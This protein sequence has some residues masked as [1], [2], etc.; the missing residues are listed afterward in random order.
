[1]D[2][3]NHARRLSTLAQM[4]CSSCQSCKPR[5]RGASLRFPLGQRRFCLF[6]TRTGTLR[7]RWLRLPCCCWSMRNGSPCYIKMFTSSN[8]WEAS[9]KRCLAV[10]HV[11]HYRDGQQ[12][13]KR[14]SVYN[15]STVTRH[16][17]RSRLLRT[18]SSVVSE[19]KQSTSKNESRWYKKVRL[20]CFPRI[21]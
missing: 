6:W 21:Q 1:M 2:N 12:A 4:E 10:H 17:K 15:A 19:V 5:L 11:S 13:Y 14:L 7:T 8:G 9:F 20:L 16:Q 3:R 18:N